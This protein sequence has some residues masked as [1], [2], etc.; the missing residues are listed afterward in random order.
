VIKNIH[1]IFTQSSVEQF[2][3]NIDTIKTVIIGTNVTEIGE[4]AFNGAIKLTKIIIPNTVTIIGNSAFNATHS[5]K[6]IQLPDSITSLGPSAF[7]STLLKFIIVPHN[8]SNI[9]STAFAGDV[10]RPIIMPLPSKS[11]TIGN[12]LFYNGSPHI[13]VYDSQ[14][15]AYYSATYA[16]AGINSYFNINKNTKYTY[17]DIMNQY[18][19][20]TINDFVYAGY[21]TT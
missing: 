11:I 17:I 12:D 7:Q 21:P 18:S 19:I 20:L 8:I 9:G 6:T 14:V 4:L 10:L 5:L 1:P 3:F 2:N 16:N 13:F 15:N